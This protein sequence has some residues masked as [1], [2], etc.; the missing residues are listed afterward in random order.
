MQRSPVLSIGLA[1]RNGEEYIA[2]CIDSVLTQ[3]FR[4]LELV[5]CDN[6]SDDGT[7]AVIEGYLRSDPRIS[8]T[9]NDVN[10]GLYANVKRVLELSRG[11]YFRWISADDWLEPGCLSKCVH[12]LERRR[13]AV[14]VTTWF[15][16][17]TKDGAQRYEEYQGEFPTSDDPARRFERILWLFRQRDATY[18]PVYGVYRREALLRARP[19]RPSERADWLLSVEL[20]LMGPILH[21]HERL[22]H[23]TRDYPVGIDQA[24]VRRRLDPVRAEQLNS[25]P[26]RLYRDLYAPAVMA[27]LTPKQLRRCRRALRR[28]WL[29][30]V[31]STAR[32]AAADTRYRIVGD[33]RPFGHR[34][35][36]SAS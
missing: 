22:A 33:A 20:A 34:P 23:R 15:T 28:T 32:R 2:R 6:A 1:V 4:D 12:A 10:I 16:I 35:A 21:I 27:D 8:L 3:D 36:S 30:E 31:V 25:S 29:D 7:V 18:D 26:S 24:I 14:G 9:I 17:H 5:I 19:L 13:D 11:T